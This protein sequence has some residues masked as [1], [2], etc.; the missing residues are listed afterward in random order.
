MSAA[1]HNG[2]TPG[3]YWSVRGAYRLAP[4]YKKQMVE[5][6]ATYPPVPGR[7]VT[8]HQRHLN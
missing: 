2:H 6:S 3:A 5:K 4:S 8:P 1:Q 7:R